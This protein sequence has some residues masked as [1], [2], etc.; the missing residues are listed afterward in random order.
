MNKKLH[1]GPNPKIFPQPEIKRQ[2]FALHIRRSN[3]E[4]E[5]GITQLEAANL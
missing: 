2:H 1:S 3:T 4:E 5:I